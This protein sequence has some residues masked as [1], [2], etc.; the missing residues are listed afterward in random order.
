MSVEAWW[1]DKWPDKTKQLEEKPVPV[2]F[3]LP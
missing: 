3:I 2:P 1:N